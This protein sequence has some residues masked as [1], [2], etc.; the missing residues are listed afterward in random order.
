VFFNP[1]AEELSWARA[2]GYPLIPSEYDV[3]QPG[4]ATGSTVIVEPMNFSHV[5]GK[6]SIKGNLEAA[7]FISYR[8][9]LGTG[10]A[11]SQWLQVGATMTSLPK[12]KVLGVLD[13][14]RYAN[15]LYTLRI[16]V[17]HSGNMADNSYLVILINNSTTN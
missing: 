17:L 1:P 4:S 10:L 2:A 12:G 6:I 3:Y 13:T 8:L 5:K 16:Q 9:D 15:G 14:T 7:G 11:P